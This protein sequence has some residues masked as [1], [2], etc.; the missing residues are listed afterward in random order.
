VI[1]TLTS[2]RVVRRLAVAWIISAAVLGT[3]L[4]VR[5]ATSGGNVV[6]WWHWVLLPAAGLV[7]GV[8]AGAA[9]GARERDFALPT[10]LTAGV[11]SFA[12][13]LASPFVLEMAVLAVAIATGHGP[14]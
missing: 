9:F 3:A 5:V 7:P 11:I 10:P 1:E 2:P 12:V 13:G 6:W 8:V 4:A 14:E